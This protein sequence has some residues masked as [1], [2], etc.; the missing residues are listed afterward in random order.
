MR[1]GPSGQLAIVLGLILTRGA[2][3]IAT[4]RAGAYWD[5]HVYRITRLDVGA[6]KTLNIELFLVLLYLIC[7]LFRSNLPC[8]Y[9]LA[10]LT[11]LAL[12]AFIRPFKSG[13]ER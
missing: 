13:S 5:E 12:N 7:L 6:M 2:F 4:A 11:V 8:H 3:Y 1:R 10:I 9:V